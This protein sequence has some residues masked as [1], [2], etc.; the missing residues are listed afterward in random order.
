[1]STISQLIQD[2]LAWIH[3]TGAGGAVAEDGRKLLSDVAAFGASLQ[4]AGQYG[5]ELATQVAPVAAELAAV[6]ATRGL[7]LPADL[8]AGAA[9]AAVAKTLSEA[10]AAFMAEWNK[11]QASATLV[12]TAPADSDAAP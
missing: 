9:I 1:M 4:A 12:A 5:P 8:A 2:G 10:E 7:S 3:G 6:A 11:L